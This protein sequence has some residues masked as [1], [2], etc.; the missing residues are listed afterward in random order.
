MNKICN[1]IV[2]ILTI[3]CSYSQNKFKSQ[4]TRI[5]TADKE[6]S[7]LNVSM[8]IDTIQYSSKLGIQFQVK[9]E[10]EDEKPVLLKNISES[11]IFGLFDE[12]NKNI[13]YPQAH[14]ALTHS[15]GTVYA[16]EPF[17]IV[18]AKIN[19]KNVA[20]RY[21]IMETVNVP[22]RGSYEI[23]I[24]IDSVLSKDA[25]KPY[26]KKDLIRIMPGVYHFTGRVIIDDGKKGIVYRMN[27]LNPFKVRYK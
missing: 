14:R 16:V 23:L 4:E 17:K 2:F 9:I 8:I 24:Q 13:M 27:P 19:G 11:L 15:D 25:Q 7:N 3:S 20:K 26:Y 12:T 21:M 5:L 1:L 18:G 6:S 10:N 22:A